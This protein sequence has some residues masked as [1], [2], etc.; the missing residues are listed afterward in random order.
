M[1]EKQRTLSFEKSEIKLE[2]T[3]KNLSNNSSSN[4]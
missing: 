3:T 1:E 2:S 4:K